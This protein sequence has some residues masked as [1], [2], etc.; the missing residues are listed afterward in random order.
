VIVV[1]LRVRG[2]KRELEYSL[3][4]SADDLLSARAAFKKWMK[5]RTFNPL[6]GA[7]GV[8]VEYGFVRPQVPWY[9]KLKD[10]DRI[11]AMHAIADKTCR[12][13]RD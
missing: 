12:I 6:D 8:Q 3:P 5:S 4:V 11:I 13:V 2:E 9:S 7:W 1:A 10:F